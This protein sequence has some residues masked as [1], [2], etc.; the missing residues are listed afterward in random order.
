MA[1]CQD[2]II[3]ERSVDEVITVI[4]PLALS[5][6]LYSLITREVITIATSDG[7]HIIPLLGQPIFIQVFINGLNQTEFT[8]NSTLVNLPSTLDILVGDTLKVTYLQIL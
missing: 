3:I 7:E 2:I 5:G 4:E 6:G 1:D 8:Y